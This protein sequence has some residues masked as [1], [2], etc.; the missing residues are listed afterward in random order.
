MNRH[1]II[2]G[3]GLAGYTLAREWR[4]RD[5]DSDLTLVTDG[6]G[7]FYSKPSLSNAFA[8]NKTP[9]M[10]VTASA[11]KMAHQLN[12]HVLTRSPV[13]RIDVDQRSITLH[14]GRCLHF[15][16]LAIAVGARP[17]PLDISG[18]GTE[19]LLTI[20]NLDDYKR[21]RQKLEGRHHVTLVGGGLIG[22]EFANDLTHAGFKV[23]VVSAGPTALYPLVPEALG[24]ALVEH[25][26][27]L[28][29]SWHFGTT[30]TEIDRD[31]NRW[32][33]QLADGACWT[34][35]IVVSAIGLQP[36]ISLAAQT[37]LTVERGFVVNDF[38]QTNIDSVFALGDCAQWRGQVLP[39]VMPLMT[40]A[41]AIAQTLTGSPTPVVFPVMPIVV[42]TP[43]YPIVVVP[44]PK[45][46]HGHWTLTRHE[47]GL[48][49]CCFDAENRL[50]GFALGGQNTRE[51]ATLVKQVVA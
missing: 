32:S 25:L 9:E 45:G 48:K 33:V 18:S 17:R 40:Q 46:T 11:E 1:L 13:S 10:L 41:R 47:D 19:A 42:K 14:D 28:G 24:H 8:Q 21:F 35:D 20:N 44:P 12:A 38:F 7:Q 39:Y 29:V 23:S 50:R 49:A 4:K 31:G 16:H 30:L 5:P 37:P 26:A 27:P 15:S 34:T 2:I 3:T 22:C 36:D 43:A 51:R 6:D